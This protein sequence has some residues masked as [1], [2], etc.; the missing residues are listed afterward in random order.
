[1]KTTEMEKIEE[2]KNQQKKMKNPPSPPLPSPHPPIELPQSP[3]SSKSYRP[4]LANFSLCNS[5]SVGGPKG[6]N[7]LLFDSLQTSL[8][9]LS[10]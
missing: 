10:I 5:C 8:P 1:M 2:T 6:A 9:K 4:S 7:F 3:F